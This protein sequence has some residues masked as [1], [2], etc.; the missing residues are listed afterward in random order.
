V[1]KKWPR[2][3]KDSISPAGRMAARLDATLPLM[4]S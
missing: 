1:Q 2:V 3:T 4:A